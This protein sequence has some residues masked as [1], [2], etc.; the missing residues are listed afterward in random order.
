MYTNW[1]FLYYIRWIKGINI[2]WI[3][4]SIGEILQYS[5]YR[6][7]KT[8][9]TQRSKTVEMSTKAYVALSTKWWNN[10]KHFSFKN[11]LALLF[12][13][14]HLVGLMVLALF[15]TKSVC[16]IWMPTTPIQKKNSGNKA[17]TDFV[18]LNIFHAW[19]VSRP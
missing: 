2:N 7:P 18:G 13:L 3:K 19:K 16:K 4:R 11:C 9:V 14:C 10:N 17:K 6:F 5:I 12:A 1:I 8:F 15:S